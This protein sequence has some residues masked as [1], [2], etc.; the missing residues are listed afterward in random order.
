MNKNACK[1]NKKSIKKKWFQCLPNL[2]TVFVCPSLRK[3]KVGVSR[4]FLGLTFWLKQENVM[5]RTYG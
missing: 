4:N 1:N 5:P 3:I 2:M